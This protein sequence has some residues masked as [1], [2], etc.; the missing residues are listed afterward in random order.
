MQST[1]TATH[2]TV[3]RRHST[4]YTY[5]VI[6]KAR[7]EN[8]HLFVLPPHS[9]HA[10]QPLDVSVFSPFKQALNTAIHKFMHTNPTRTL[11]REELPRM[12]CSA[13]K[14]AMTPGTIMTGFRKAGIF[15]YNSSAPTSHILP[16]DF[17]QTTSK[18]SRKDRQ[19]NRAVHL[20]L[21]G[22]L[23]NFENPLP[24]EAKKSRNKFIPPQDALVSTQTM[25]E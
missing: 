21:D 3:I 6:Q 1:Q 25:L 22:H 8:I 20:L 2:P 14:S 17:G 16:P 11:T 13:F 12:I 4:H 7:Q 5:N 10:L 23:Q 24:T 18:L 19:E 9:S 15:P